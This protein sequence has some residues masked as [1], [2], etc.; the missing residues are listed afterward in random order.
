M[1]LMISAIIVFVSIYGF[2]NY[3][4]GLRGYEYLE[5]IIP[6]LNNKV[7]WIFFWIIVLSFIVGRFN[8]KLIPGFFQKTS[9]LI[10]SYWMAIM[11][12]TL[13]L[14]LLLDVTRFI[15][16]HTNLKNI[17]MLQIQNINFYIGIL[18]FACIP[19][20][21][22]Y[23]AYHARN[24]NVN[25]Y[26]IRI[27]KNTTTLK[28]LSVVFL[29]DIHLGNIVDNYQLEHIVNK[30]NNLSP[31]IVLIGGDIIDDSIEPYIKQGMS[32]TFRKIKSKYGVYAILGN[33]DGTAG[34]QSDVIKYFEDGGMKVLVDQYA[35]I[36]DAFYIVGRADDGM[37]RGASKRKPL[38]EILK[39]INISLPIILMDHN[40]AK[41][42]EAAQQSVDLQLS[43]HTHGGQFFPFTLITKMIYENDWGYLKKDNF[44]LI[45]SSG[46]GTWG[47]PIRIG[48][49]SEIVEVNIEFRK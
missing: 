32:Q 9:N 41:H 47:P 49:S 1:P 48:S 40:P 3:Y 15:I 5:S 16:N 8:S 14:F 42:F 2:T 24:I 10:G 28:N 23:G 34:N 13:M 43:G 11:L 44:Q 38:E 25:S 35:K 26:S 4:I 36:E 33:H 20:V 31:D 46:S 30:I 12:Y 39:D 19:V 17:K 29:S 27:D 6:S 18:I 21:I 22:I 45:V 37:P 7:Y